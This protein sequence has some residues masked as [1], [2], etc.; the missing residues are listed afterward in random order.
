[1]NFSVAALNSITPD[2]PTH[3]VLQV[4]D[5][6]VYPGHGVG[7]IIGIEEKEVLGC[8]QRF[9]ILRIC[10]NRMQIMVPMQN[11]IQVGLRRIISSKEANQVFSLLHSPL[12]QFES[13]NWNRRYR[14]CM[15]KIKTGDIFAIAQVFR[16]F[17]LLQKKKSLSF[18]E[19]RMLQK[20]KDLLLEE[21]SL[22]KACSESEVE[23]QLEQIFSR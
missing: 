21:L 11:T 18:G 5:R 2:E 10:T 15:D 23:A 13:N 9:Y 7:E 12:G 20:A 8:F 17:T 3:L 14:E 22:A 6:A 4:G 19:T 16:D 1:M